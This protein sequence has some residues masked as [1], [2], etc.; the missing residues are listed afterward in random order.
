M[1]TGPLD[2]YSFT[3]PVDYASGNSKTL[4]YSNRPIGHY[5]ILWQSE[6]S[7]GDNSTILSMLSSATNAAINLNPPFR[8]IMNSGGGHTG[9]GFIQTYSTNFTITLYA[10]GYY[11]GSYSQTF[12]VVLIYLGPA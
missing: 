2:F 8:G 7:I 4:S 9:F 5:L 1:V 12:R 3:I 10:W 6:S 11:P